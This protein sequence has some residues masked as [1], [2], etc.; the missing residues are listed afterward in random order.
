MSS[1]RSFPG[2]RVHVSRVGAAL[3]SVSAGLAGCGGSSSRDE[4]SGETAE[5]STADAETSAEASSSAD[6]SEGG[7]GFTLDPTGLNEVIFAWSQGSTQFG[8]L[9]AGNAPPEAA[10][11]KFRMGVAIANDS[12]DDP[13]VF[14]HRTG[15]AHHHLFV[16][17]GYVDAH[18]T[19]A[20]TSTHDRTLNRDPRPINDMSG[21][22]VNRSGYWVPVM[23]DHGPDGEVG[24]ASA[25]ADDRPMVM[26]FNQ[27]YYVK[28]PRGTETFD[29]QWEAELQPMP[30]GLQIIT[31]AADY[32]FNCAYEPHVADDPIT[33]FEPSN[34][35]AGITWPNDSFW[36][37]NAG[38]GIPQCDT[39]VANNVTMRI[40]FPDCWDGVHLTDADHDDDPA[41]TSP[42]TRHDH[43]AYSDGSTGCPSS[44]PVQ[45]GTVQYNFYFPIP[46]PAYDTSKFYLASDVSMQDGYTITCPEGQHGCS[47]HG[48]WM[49]GWEESA[50]DAMV[51]TTD[52]CLGSLT[53][54]CAAGSITSSQTLMQPENGVAN[55]RFGHESFAYE[56][57]YDKPILLDPPATVGTFSFGG[58]NVPDE[59]TVTW[60]AMATC[61]GADG[62]DWTET[63][64]HEEIQAAL[65]TDPG[66]P[67]AFGTYAFDW[68][69]LG[70]IGDK[71]AHASLNHDVPCTGFC[72]Q[73]TVTAG[74]ETVVGDCE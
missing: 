44:H 42:E 37:P 63:F 35:A 46:D 20:P 72:F 65:V 50:M 24:T 58:S 62:T 47:N 19:N 52:G 26:G 59:R 15:R 49:N 51:N 21:R 38:A 1:L 53:A 41:T 14:P 54:H 6:T 16:G 55:W 2:V 71:R 8:M 64:T 36:P 3:L 61:E 22:G 40:T 34:A 48:D 69:A 7:A 9:E 32:V 57:R 29:A 60:E 31:D 17:N 74:G 39:T 4:G 10:D 33:Y 70:T 18:S 13:I 25:Q 67:S 45:L 43:M 30:P 28:S 73:P 56:F 12:Y 23:Y 66:F 5:E 27:I 11:Y 68:L